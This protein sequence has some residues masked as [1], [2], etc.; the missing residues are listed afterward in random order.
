MNS[1]NVKSDMN[2][3]TPQLDKIIDAIE[4][5][6]FDDVQDEYDDYSILL[7]KF[8]FRK[9]VTFELYEA[10][11]PPRRH[12]FELQLVTNSPKPHYFVVDKGFGTDGFPTHGPEWRHCGYMMSPPGRPMLASGRGHACGSPRDHNRC[13]FHKSRPYGNRK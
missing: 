10:H 3:V 6:G 2:S 13:S 8:E 12:D 7:Q 4:E 11:F 5:R 1:P 9:L